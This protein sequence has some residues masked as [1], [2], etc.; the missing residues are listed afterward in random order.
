[1][2]FKIPNAGDANFARQSDVDAGDFEIIVRGLD[3]TGVFSGCEVTAQGSPDMTVAV[4]AGV[5]LVAG[6]R[7]TVSSGNVTIAAA[8]ATFARTDLITVDASGTK[9][10]VAGTP[11]ST[12]SYPAIPASRAVLAAIHVPAA[13]TAV[14][15]TQITD[16]RVMLR[17]ATSEDPMGL[18][19]AAS[20]PPWYVTGSG[21]W[22][23]ANRGL[24]SRAVGK[25]SISNIGMRVTTASGNISVGL[26]VNSGSGR[27]AVPGTRVA[28]SG[29]VACP[30][31]GD[32]TVSIGA[33]V[34]VTHGSHWFGMSCDNTTAA[35]IEHTGG[36]VQSIAQGWMGFMA[37]AHP[38]PDPVTLTPGHSKPIHLVSA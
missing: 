1:M 8:D 21:V 17:L 3:A 37:G 6:S 24:F 35:F 9:A 23:T 34:A 27:T 7:V 18:E 11:S 38:I 13:D 5:A 30:I 2:S 19:H 28:T 4:A 15:S 16:K 20:G 14:N 33:T 36:N 10:V 32:A 22:P 29:A 12:V 31:A 26:Y 25:A